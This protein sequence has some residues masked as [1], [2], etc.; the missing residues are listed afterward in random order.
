MFVVMIGVL[1]SAVD[2]TIVVLAL[3][4]I[5][6]D[7]NITLAA[8]TWVVVGYLLVVTV[9]ATQLGRFGD[10]FGRV[11]MYK[12]GFLVFAI[13]SVLCAVAWNGAEPHRLPARPGRRRRT[14]RGQQRRDHLGALSAAGTRPRLRLQ[15]LRLL[16]RLGPRCPARRRRW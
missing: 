13:G 14:D 11:R 15:R 1:I 8:V 5:E 6:E 2:G 16:V 3:P 10:M 4:A 9:L 12:A 7:L